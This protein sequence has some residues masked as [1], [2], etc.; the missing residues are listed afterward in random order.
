MIDSIRLIDWWTNGGPMMDKKFDESHRTHELKRYITT[1]ITSWQTQ[2]I[3]ERN[4]RCSV[5]NYFV[6]SDSIWNDHFILPISGA[7]SVN[8]WYD[9]RCHRT[10]QTHL[11]DAATTR[12]S[13]CN[14]IPRMISAVLARSMALKVWSRLYCINVNATALIQLNNVNSTTLNR[15]FDVVQGGFRGFIEIEKAREISYVYLHQ[16]F[17]W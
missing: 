7:L 14:H 11:S 8:S 6:A 12:I 4:S 1:M 3:F 9:C 13:Q 17:L 2:I 5:W 16:S 15:Y 10:N